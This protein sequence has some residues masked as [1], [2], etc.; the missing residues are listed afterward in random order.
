M[1]LL[2]N[3]RNVLKETVSTCKLDTCPYRSSVF[4]T[5]AFLFIMNIIKHLYMS[6]SYYHCITDDSDL[7]LIRDIPRYAPAADYYD[8]AS[9]S[10]DYSPWYTGAG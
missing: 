10:G 3:F 9:G 5:S 1:I 7:L 2:S 6:G 4:R 8:E